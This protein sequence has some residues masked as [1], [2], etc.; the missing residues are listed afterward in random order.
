MKRLYTVKMGAAA[1]K[2]KSDSAGKAK[3]EARIKY[4]EEHG[5]HE[6]PIAHVVQVRHA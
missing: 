4:R 3:Q 1:Y 6:I 5:S 2:I